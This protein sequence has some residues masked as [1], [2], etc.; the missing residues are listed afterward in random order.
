MTEPTRAEWIGSALTRYEQPLIR[1]AAGITGNLEQAR[2]VVQDTF[3][4]LCAADVARLDGRL[5]AWLYTVCRN[6]ALDVRKKEGRMKTLDLDGAAAV[7]SAGPAPSTV[8]ERH[9]AAEMVEAVLA[10][11][12][13]AQQ[14]AFRLKFEHGMTY[15]EISEVMGM[16]LS[17]VSYTV[18]KAI[19]ALRKRLQG[20]LNVAQEA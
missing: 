6:R 10:S 8:A 12:P 1:Y 5:A 16:P 14:E 11:L 18:S 4:R 7:R 2:D 13:E 20:D 3:L 19:D 9:E 17:T 15:R